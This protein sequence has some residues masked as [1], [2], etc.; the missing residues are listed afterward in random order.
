MVLY[1]NS[2]WCTGC[3]KQIRDPY[4]AIIERELFACCYVAVPGCRQHGILDEHILVIIS[5]QPYHD[6]HDVSR[7]EL[8]DRII[9]TLGYKA[10]ANSLEGIY[11]DD[12]KSTYQ[13][14]LL[15]EQALCRSGDAKGYFIFSP[16]REQV[17]KPLPLT[18]GDWNGPIWV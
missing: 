5:R 16:R 12:Y 6:M 1:I 4:P 14:S 13:H 7:L 8:Y 15:L 10:P 18:G 9:D 17:P 3:Q 2:A 11:N